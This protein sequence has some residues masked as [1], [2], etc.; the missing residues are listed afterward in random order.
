MESNTS[1]FVSKKRARERER[2]VGKTGR[3]DKRDR[4]RKAGREKGG[5]ETAGERQEEKH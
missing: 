2:V 1:Y 5:Y 4:G 3:E